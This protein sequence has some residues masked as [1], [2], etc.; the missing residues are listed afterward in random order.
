MGKQHPAG[1]NDKQKD[2]AEVNCH[3]NIDASVSKSLE[4]WCICRIVKPCAC[5][6]KK[7]GERDVTPTPSDSEK[8]QEKED[9]NRSTPTPEDSDKGKLVCEKCEKS[10]NSGGLNDTL[11]TFQDSYDDKDIKGLKD[12]IVQVSGVEKSDNVKCDIGKAEP[13]E[14]KARREINDEFDDCVSKLHTLAN[15]DFELHVVD[16]NTGDSFQKDL[17]KSNDRNKDKGDKKESVNK[18]ENNRQEGKVID[19]SQ[20]SVSE[21]EMDP[22]KLDN[23]SISSFDHFDASFCS[24]KSTGN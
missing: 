2:D 22:A 24:L 17:I 13:F 3:E 10:S 21:A 8:Y 23:I 15:S 20:G 18:E 7:E 9:S 5:E 11:E 14:V 12:G 1:G 16:I 4:V 6:K 19:K